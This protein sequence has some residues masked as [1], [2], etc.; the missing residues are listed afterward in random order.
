MTLSYIKFCDRLILLLCLFFIVYILVPKY[1]AFS[2]GFF[3]LSADRVILAFLLLYWIFGLLI[4]KSINKLF[5]KR[6]R[7]TKNISLLLFF[8]LLLQFISVLNSVDFE[9]SLK[10]FLS[11][12]LY[13]VVSYFVILSV[14]LKNAYL[15]R[16]AKT[17][18]FASILLIGI[19]IFEIMLNQNVFAGFL[20]STSL[21]EYQ[22]QNLKGK[23]RGN[24]RRIQAS[25]ANPLTYGQYIVMIIPILFFLKNWLKRK[26]LV[27][28]TILALITVSFMIRSRS[29]TIILILSFLYGLNYLIFLKKLMVSS[30]ILT[31]LLVS[32]LVLFVYYQIDFKIVE[33]FFGEKKLIGDAGRASQIAMAVPLINDNFLFGFGFGTGSNILGFGDLDG[34]SSID[35]YFLTVVLDSGLF[36]LVLFVFILYKIF[37]KYFKTRKQNKLIVVGLIFFIINLFTLS[38]TEVHPIFYFFVALLLTLESSHENFTCNHPR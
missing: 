22:Q 8:F 11:F 30:K 10:R 38:I 25:F 4:Y 19:S 17:F 21:T 33:E 26:W 20:D 16:I 15:T 23:I 31:L 28:I 12:F 18:L 3:Y 5:R 29:V 34:T 32:F 9:M 7:S 37:I 1:I 14:P 27:N 6:L 13:I 36:T 2:V 24:E 35:N